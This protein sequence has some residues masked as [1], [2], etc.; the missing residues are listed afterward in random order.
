M[1]VPKDSFPSTLSN[2]AETLGEDRL[3]LFADL[4]EEGKIRASSPT[5]YIGN[6][7]EIDGSQAQTLARLIAIWTDAPKALARCVRTATAIKKS[8]LQK[9]ES[10]T[11]VWT[12]AGRYSL[13]SRTTFSVAREMIDASMHHV[14]IFGY[15][16]T[17]GAEPLFDI[18]SRKAREG[19]RVRI[20]LDNAISQ[21][22]TLKDLWR[23]DVGLLEVMEMGDVKIHAKLI[24]V[25]GIDLLVT[26]ANLTYSGLQNNIEIGLRIKGKAASEVDQLI[27][28][29][30]ASGNLK[31]VNL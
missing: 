20:I 18:L 1:T 25:D 31:R 13:P 14:N 10:V 3:L 9:S 2:L 19:V 23:T 29:L 12:G 17:T 16:I 30:I 7:L 24:G 26:S 8:M 28:K 21:L 27:L 11:L 22:R 5:S 6:Q 15:L 4:V